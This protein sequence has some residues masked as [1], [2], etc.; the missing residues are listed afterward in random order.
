MIN[1]LSA[2]THIKKTELIIKSFV[3]YFNLAL[4]IVLCIYII[5]QL[6][7]SSVPQI[8]CRCFALDPNGDF[9]P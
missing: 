1:T 3:I 4:N 8:S 7:E 6:L 9:P 2:L 5:A